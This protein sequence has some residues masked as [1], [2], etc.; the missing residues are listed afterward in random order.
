[1]K[2]QLVLLAAATLMVAE[3][4]PLSEARNREN[5]GS[6]RHCCVQRS[7]AEEQVQKYVGQNVDAAVVGST[8]AHLKKDYQGR[9]G[10][11]VEAVIS[12]KT[13]QHIPRT[14][15]SV[16][17]YSLLRN[18][19]IRSPDAQRNRSGG[20]HYGGGGLFTTY[21]SGFTNFKGKSKIRPFRNPYKV[22]RPGVYFKRFRY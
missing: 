5:N 16:P 20:H 2:A 4:R 9:S 15:D 3:A 11:S 10:R 18:R 7:I 8:D 1:M 14:S 6:P 19:N 13:K 22:Y 12:M 21:N 17:E